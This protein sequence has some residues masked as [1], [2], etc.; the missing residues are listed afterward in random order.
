M[1]LHFEELKNHDFQVQNVNIFR[2]KP[3]YRSL[4]TRNRGRSKNGFLYVVSGEGR[5][6][7]AEGSFILVPGSVVYLPEGSRH[8][9]EILTDQIEFYC[10]DFDLL[11][12]G[13]PVYFSTGPL[14]MCHNADRKFAEAVQEM[15]GNYEFINDT[16]AKTALLCTMFQALSRE[17]ESR[18]TARLAPALRY[19]LEHLTEKV[20][21][22]KLAS[23]CYLSTAQFYNLFREA[24][25][26]APLEYRSELLANKA[27]YLL[28]TGSFSVTEIAEMLGFES[29]SYFSRFFKKH[30][31]LSPARYQRDEA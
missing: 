21:C 9:F 10:V 6:S 25:H 13:E 19:M 28:K 5:Y 12:R 18:N 14:K 1:I 8:L 24:Y 17:R 23:L 4:D 16:V 15:A 29:V 11:I 31:G 20:D 26:S 2:R 7:S 22:G 30:R 27:A 3:A